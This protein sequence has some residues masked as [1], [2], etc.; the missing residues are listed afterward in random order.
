MSRRRHNKDRKPTA[1]TAVRGFATVK[2]QLG[3]VVT[4][5]GKISMTTAE[6]DPYT[7]PL[8]VS[9]S[10]LEEI[11][12]PSRRSSTTHRETSNELRISRSSRSGRCLMMVLRVSMTPWAI[13][14]A[15]EG[16]IWKTSLGVRV[17]LWC[18][19]GRLRGLR[20]TR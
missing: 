6:S 18:G 10:K 14:R 17:I 16:G 3:V 19:R 4:V 7:P 8:I 12:P 1:V 5:G 11:V 9:V 20:V 15:V 2:T 13:S